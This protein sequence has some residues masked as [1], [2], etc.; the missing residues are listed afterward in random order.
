METMLLDK[1]MKVLFANVIKSFVVFIQGVFEAG[2]DAKGFKS[3]NSN[4]QNFIVILLQV[5]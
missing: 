1:L 3:V 2:V 4:E 5:K